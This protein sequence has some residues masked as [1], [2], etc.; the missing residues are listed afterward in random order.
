[1]YTNDL[2]IESEIKCP[3]CGYLYFDSHET[4]NREESI[5]EE[6]PECGKKFE[7]EMCVMIDYRSNQNCKLNNE[8]HEWE[9]AWW[10]KSDKRASECKKCGYVKHYGEE[11]K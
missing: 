10:D 2:E 6:C 9:L 4:L 7:V 1:M 8:Q 11:E 3:Y 5:I